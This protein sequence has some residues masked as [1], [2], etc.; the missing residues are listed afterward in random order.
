M[1]VAYGPEGRPAIA[2][3]TPQAQL[4]S[5]S[6]ERLLYCPNCRGVVHVRGGAE[7]RT[8]L[9]FAHQKGECAWSTE[10]ESVRHM[11]GKVVLA[12]WLRDQFPSAT[13]TLEERLPEPNRIADIFVAHSN[14]TRQ[15]IEFQ[16][17]PLDIEEWRHRHDAYRRA[18][19]I[20][21]WIIGTNRREKQEAFIEAILT[22]AREVLFLDPQVTPPRTWLRWPINRALAQEWQGNGPRKESYAPILL[23][24]VGR[25]GY[26]ATLIGALSE[27]RIDEQGRILHPRRIVIEA[28]TQL[29]QSMSTASAPDEST[30]ATYLR[31][32]VDEQT[33]RG[34][35]L[36]LL[37]SYLLD[38]ELLRR[39]NYG[40]G[41][42][43]QPL[44]VEDIQRVRKARAWL[45]T[46]TRRGISVA[47]LQEIT[48][49]I[50]FVGPYAAFAGYV[51][52]LIAL[53][54]SPISP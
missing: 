36:P 12:Q 48:R 45:A 10:G 44:S 30:L 34:I 18:G 39:Y 50:P 9:H 19:I 42:V 40:R 1:L 31:Q 27:V 3:E 43:D 5:W 54:T 11:R 6:H 52:M 15:A 8:Q 33:L 13:V 25:L 47:Q 49:E 46:L 41:Q 35:I 22:M 29:L 53:N 7:K 26:G 20:D 24:W 23:G 37:R 14:G 16:C 28:R 51:E 2:E 17:A 21:T 32:T 4:Q 38:P